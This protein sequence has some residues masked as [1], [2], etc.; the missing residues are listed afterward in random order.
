MNSTARIKFVIAV[1]LLIIIALF[2]IVVF[3]LINISKIKKEIN[4]Q[5]HQIQQLEKVLDQNNKTPNTDY[6]S[7]TGE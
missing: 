2:S 1:A 7:I 4:A 3:Q 5:Q 6:D